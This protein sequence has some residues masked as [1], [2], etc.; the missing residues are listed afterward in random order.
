MVVTFVGFVGGYVAVRPGQPVPGRRLAATLVTWFTFLPSFVFILIGGPS[1][2][3]PTT[4]LLH[5]PADRI[6][7]AVVG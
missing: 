3:R 1:S 2:R 4:T 7:A 6:T 5:G